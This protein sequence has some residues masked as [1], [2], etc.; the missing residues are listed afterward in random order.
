MTDAMLTPNDVTPAWLTALLTKNGNFADVTGVSFAPIGTGQVG[1]TYR[2]ELEY[3]AP[4]EGAPQT[5]VGK[6]PSNDPLSRA[7]GK[8]HMTYVRESRFYQQFAGTVPLPVPH[9]LYIAFDEESHD[10]ALI[11]HDLPCHV[12][13]NQL[14]VPSVEEAMLAMGAAAQFHA[15]WWG[16]PRLDQMEWL[17]GTKAVPPPLDVEALYAMFWP[18]FCDR[19]GARISAPI[20]QVG[21]AFLGRVADWAAGRSG[22]RCLTH[23]DFRPDN[24]LYDLEDPEHPIVIVD[25]QTVGVG[26]GAGDIAYYIGT[27][28]DPAARKAHETSLFTHYRD[29]LAKLGVPPEDIAHLWD[30]YRA[31]A[32]AGFLMGVT[33]SMVVG[34]TER[35]DAM[36][37]AMCERAAA[38]VLD[39]G[40][41]ALPKPKM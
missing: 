24:M 26:T 31:A 33:A 18:A 10:F 19:Y 2:F 8:S 21:D 41:A 29:T 6:F 3:A 37:L 11:M 38:M 15:A 32:F 39:H 13:G 12:A 35:G 16:D 5:L 17:N 27:A 25:W 7:T 9:H 22:P 4:S 40:K 28:L 20:K 1:A 23:N 30:D 34:Q 36:F 14:H